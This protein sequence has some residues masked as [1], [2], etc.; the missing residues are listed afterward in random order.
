L[1]VTFEK[2]AARDCRYRRDCG[3]NSDIPEDK[4]RRIGGL[5]PDRPPL[6]AGAKKDILR[7]V[8]QFF[9]RST[10]GIPAGSRR[11]S[12]R[13]QPRGQVTLADIGKD[14][15][16]PLALS[17]PRSNLERREASGPG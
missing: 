11:L 14:R 4:T 6:V 5:V 13:E 9:Q 15:H 10:H 17:Q 3:K 7:A 2:K 8:Q 16:D 1:N 12:A